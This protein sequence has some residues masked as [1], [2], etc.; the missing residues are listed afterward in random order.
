MLNRLHATLHRPEHGWD[1]VPAAH[2]EAYSAHAASTF[3]QEVVPRLEAKVGALEGKRIL[4]LGGGP[5]DYSIE[6]CRRG[7]RVVWHDVSRRY[8]DLARANALQAGVAIEFS[9]GYLED[10]RSRWADE[11]DLVFCR[12]CWSYC[13][14]D[15]RFARIL[16]SLIK[17]GGAGYIECNTPALADP[18]GLRKLQYLLNSK[19]GL[20]IGHPYPPHGRIESLFRRLPISNIEVDY[21]FQFCDRVLFFKNDT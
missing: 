2:L 21:S 17:P 13:M 8:M 19:L 18:R 4:D 9:L 1:P 3:D 11:F 15:Q 6:F 7:A 14:D 20:K 12:V 10:A 16:Y 5:G